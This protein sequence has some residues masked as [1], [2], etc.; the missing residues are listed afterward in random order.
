VA[1]SLAAYRPEAWRFRSPR[2]TPARRLCYNA[3]MRA[4]PD[5]GLTRVPLWVYTDPDTYAR[6]QTRI[7]AGPFWSYVGLA[8]EIP[9]PGDFKRTHVGDKPVV[10]V[11]DD[12]G[13]AR[14]LENRCAHRGVQFCRA[15]FGTVKEFMCPYHQ[16]TYDLGGRLKAVP[17]R[18]G[19]RKQGGMPADFRLEDHPVQPLAVH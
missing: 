13:R 3:P 8:A 6:E 11:R 2:A 14:V 16:W 4:W 15:D 19:M 18:R 7:F 1:S 9:H 17:L 12:G 5:E 10:L